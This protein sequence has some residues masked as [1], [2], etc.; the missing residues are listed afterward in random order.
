MP[1]KNRTVRAWSCTGVLQT[2]VAIACIVTA[3]VSVRAQ[4]HIAGSVSDQTGA[5]IAQ[6]SVEFASGPRTVRTRTN[7]HGEFALVSEDAS[8]TLTVQAAGFE[9]ARITLDQKRSSEQLQIRLEPAGVIE[10]IVVSADDERI[11]VTPVSQYAIGRG[12]IASSGALTIDDVLRQVPGF[13]LFRRSGGLTANPTTQGVSLRGV[14]ANGASRALVMYDGVPL[15]SPFGGWAYWN[16]LPR[17]SVESAEVFNGGA[18]DLYGSGALGG[19][20]NITTRT[21]PAT[22][23][24]LEAS[25]GNESTGAV[26]LDAG[27]SWG[28][29][30]V[31]LALQALRTGGYVVVPPDQRGRVDTPAGTSD[32]T[33]SVR[34]STKHG[35]LRI[36]SF[37]ESRNNGTPLQMN[38]T[39]ITSLDLGFDLASVSIRVYG[40]HEVF[41]QTFSAVSA[42]RNSEVLTNRQRN[43]SQQLGFA[44]QW[45]H[46]L[47][48]H[49]SLSAGVEGRDVRGHSAER[50]VDAG[51]RQRSFGVFGSDSI[52]FGNWLVNAGTR[53]DRWQNYDGFSNSNHF[54]DVS[55]TAVSPRVSVLRR[56]ENGVSV[57][58]S[59]YRAFRAPTLNELY[60]N[61][62]VGNVVTNANSALTAERLTGGE[63]GIGF[64]RF[65]DIVF[66]RGNF[67]WNQIDDS[68]ANVTLSTTPAL[69]TRQR[70][71][72]G[73][74]RARGIELA[75]VV[76][77]DRHWEL[78]SEY[79]LTDSTVLSFPANRALE[80]LL[81]PQIPR[82]QFNVQVTYASGKWT[83][84]AQ[85][86]FVSKQFDDDLNTLPLQRYF[87]LDADVSRSISEHV[88]LF[89]A[90]QNL[91]GVRYEISATPVFTVGP[92]VLIRGG[93]RLSL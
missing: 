74:I 36:G 33:G 23:L 6:A 31:G 93:F 39:R 91:T 85:G 79:L 20:I 32:L 86:R 28:N 18:S 29:F 5:A 88:R 27:K 16:R 13:S 61:F 92:P 46:T 22:F 37:G 82:N 1:M 21:Q 90:A 44:F 57:S 75:A 71:N 54:L 11:P 34:L 64:Q 50:F 9:T 8:G 68:I 25:G 77:P 81:V 69:I 17:V 59:F 19:V 84:G 43:P 38:D 89:F 12:E 40:S 55:E 62:R 78:A 58:G 41:N 53:V 63:A 80:G 7:E 47:G 56:F 4:T 10:R 72:L 76:K 87:T 26:S 45:Q 49:Q 42:D 35:F 83:A 24:D 51:G 2:C 66:I 30:G 67:F 70:Q 60:R 15:N 48:D 14:G 3:C 52:R 65:R 73:A